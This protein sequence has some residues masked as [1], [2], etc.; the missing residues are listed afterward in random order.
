[1]PEKSDKAGQDQRRTQRRQIPDRRKDAA[2]KRRGDQP[3]RRKD[4]IK[5]R[6]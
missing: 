6:G 2:Q 5:P 1:M 3:G 4:D